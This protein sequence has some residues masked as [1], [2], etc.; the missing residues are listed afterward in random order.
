MVQVSVSSVG[1]HAPRQTQDTLPGVQ[2]FR[3][4]GDTSMHAYLYCFSLLRH[5][6]GF[7]Q[8]VFVVLFVVGVV[9]HMKMSFVNLG[10]LRYSLPH[11]TDVIIGEKGYVTACSAMP[12]LL[13]YA[14]MYSNE[15]S[16]NIFE[17]CVLYVKCNE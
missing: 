17:T 7:R 13:F 3:H 4:Q 5:F 12:Q 16:S 1:R 9:S 11:L 14:I 10:Q 6:L 8:P 2:V 15:F